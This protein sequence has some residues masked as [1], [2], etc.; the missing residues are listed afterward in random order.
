MAGD[1]EIKLGYKLGYSQHVISIVV[2][3]LTL[4]TLKLP[5]SAGD[6]FLLKLLASILFFVTII[7]VTTINFEIINGHLSLIQTQDSYDMKVLSSQIREIALIQI[8]SLITWLFLYIGV[9]IL[10]MFILDIWSFIDPMKITFQI[11]QNL[12]NLKEITH[13]VIIPLVLLMIVHK[14]IATPPLSEKIG[15]KIILHPK[16]ELVIGEDY[17]EPLVIT[18]KNTGIKKI[19]IK[20]LV[21]EFPERVTLKIDNN[22]FEKN[23]LTL[24]DLKKVGLPTLLIPKKKCPNNERWQI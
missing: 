8:F 3:V 21:I 1:I 2:L 14:Y 16:D 18:M 13:L 6:K 15:F 20:D 11:G 7:Y 22:E 17:D 9:L 23:R 5:L 10:L 24:E 19:E 4:F 12:I